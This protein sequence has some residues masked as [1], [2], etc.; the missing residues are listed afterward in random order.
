MNIPLKDLMKPALDEL[1]KELGLQDKEVGE[2]VLGA[3]NKHAYDFALA[4]EVVMD[5]PLSPN[6]PAT[7][8]QKACGTSLEAAILIANKIALGQIDCGIAG[9][10][11]TN[12]DVPVEFKKSFSDRLLRLAAAKTLG[13]KLSALKGF[14]PGELLPK[15]PAIKEPRTGKSMGES[16]E[17]MAKEWK[18]PREEQDKLALASQENAEK[19]Y[20]AGWY[21]DLVVEYKGAKKDGTIRATSLEKLAKLKPAFDRE[22]GAGTLTAGNSSP[23]TDGASCVFLC[24]EEYAK[25]NNLEVMAY[26]TFAQSAAVD[27]VNNE[28]LLMAPAYAV[29]KLLKQANLNLQDFDYYEIHEA[30]AAQVLCTLEAWKS[31][32]FCKNKLGLDAPLGEIDFS[33][34][35]VKGGSLA[36]GHPFAATGSRIVAGLAKIIHENGGGRGLISICTAGGMGVTAIIEK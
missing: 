17:D 25:E 30:F 3:V 31:E 6:T 28:G 23:L 34:L 11:D 18:I 10:I 19:A 7:D 26:L 20:Q 29:P 14:T 33:K 2:V 5:S 12:S 24:S 16:C 21:D 9:G 15:L 22:S 8:I 13:A 32:D 35:N 27:Y 4:R 36:L 1:V